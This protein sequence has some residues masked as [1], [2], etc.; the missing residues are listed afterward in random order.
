MT[1]PA[2][3][4]RHLTLSPEGTNL[5]L[6][7]I[8]GVGYLL[9]L[10]ALIDHG[11]L[12]NG[13]EG[14]GDVFAYW[15][16]GANL[17]AGEPVYG[18]GVGGYAAF[19]YLPP[20]AQ[21][22]AFPSQLPFPVVVWLWRGVVLLGLRATVGSWRSAGIAM[23]VWPPVIS[24]LDAG[25]VH[26]LMA[27]AVAMMIRGQGVWLLPAALTKFATLVA[28]PMAL[29]DDPRGLLKGVGI[30]GVIVLVSFA[31]GPSLWFDYAR[32]ITGV[33][34]FDSGWYNLG[35]FVPLPLRVG[36][37]SA[38]IF[39]A[40]RWRRML[41]VAATLALPVLWFHGL[42]ML[43]AVAARPRDRRAEID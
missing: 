25:N 41:A 34:T 28:V 3:L 13:G 19:L 2:S 5:V 29:R 18:P 33:S 39:A 40:F 26:L 31:L 8:S 12:K 17:L 16:A 32:F 30:A 7:G 4:R 37:A 6:A 38:A 23:L 42:S 21:L 36:L 22:F 11:I 27:A 9:C 1:I 10:R 14:G 43:V 24:E 20:L 15:T 35:A